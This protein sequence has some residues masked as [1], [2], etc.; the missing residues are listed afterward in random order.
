MRPAARAALKH[1]VSAER[2]SNA[3]TYV[4]PA[5]SSGSGG[6]I[7]TPDLWVMSPTSCRCS[8]PRRVLGVW[9]YRLSARSARPRRLA[10]LPPPCRGWGVPAA[11][12]PPVGSPPQYSPALRWVTT[13]FGMGPGGASTLSATGTP[14]PRTPEAGTLLLRHAPRA[15]PRSWRAAPLL[16]GRPRAL[17][18]ATSRLH[19]ASRSGLPA[20]AGAVVARGGGLTSP[21]RGPPRCRATTPDGKR[22]QEVRPRPLGRLG[23]S[24]LPAVHL[25][26]INPVICRGSYL[27]MSGD[28]RLGEGFP[29]RCFQRFARPHVATQRCRSRDNWR[30]SGASTPVLSY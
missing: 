5:L 27:V 21:W 13:G 23:S 7:R 25:P 11:A 15:T 3:G 14:H 16:A 26:P 28:A 20:A 1:E 19:H 8:T 6:G 9:S 30:T 17:H 4:V 22:S 29:L 12:S 10:V 18:S 24:R 2:N